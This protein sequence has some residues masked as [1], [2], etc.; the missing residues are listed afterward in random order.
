MDA[1][2]S[3]RV[4]VEVKRQGDKKLKEIGSSTTELVNAAY[5]YLLKHGRIPSDAAQPKASKAS[6]KVLKGRQARAFAQTWAARAPLQVAGYD[7]TN[8]KELLEAAREERHAG[9]S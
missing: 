4:P 6:T 1:M 8:F 5:A 2:V 3:A 7:G 9:V